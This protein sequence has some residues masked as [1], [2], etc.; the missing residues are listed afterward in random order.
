[1]CFLEKKQAEKHMACVFREKSKQKNTNWKLIDM[2]RREKCVFWR[3]SKQKNT[4]RVFL[5]RKASRKNQNRKFQVNFRVD[6][7]ISIQI[8]IYKDKKRT[9]HENKERYI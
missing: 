9:R 8:Y 4:R 5:E 3:R 2:Y 1:M 6:F 7:C